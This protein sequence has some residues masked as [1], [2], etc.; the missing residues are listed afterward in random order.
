MLYRAARTE[1]FEGD[2]WAGTP[3]LGQLR[4]QEETYLFGLGFRAHGLGC[5][6]SQLRIYPTL[7]TRRHILDPAPIAT[8]VQKGLH[9]GS[10][11]SVHDIV[12]STL[13]RHPGA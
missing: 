7:E 6:M 2:A 4:G 1:A 3:F 8:E 12:L 10:L 9:I 5:M 13:G 11:P